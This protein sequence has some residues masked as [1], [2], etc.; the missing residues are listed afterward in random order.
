MIYNEYE[1]KLK[2]DNIK[3]IFKLLY[4]FCSD[5]FEPTI[6]TKSLDVNIQYTSDSNIR[7]STEYDNKNQIKKTTYIIKKKVK[8]EDIKILYLYDDYDLNIRLSACN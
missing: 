1:I 4:K 3:D 7:E 2:S 5:T 8:N 6:Y